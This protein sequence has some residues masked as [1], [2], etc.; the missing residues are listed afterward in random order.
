MNHLIELSNICKSF[1]D[2]EVLKNINLYI[3]KNEFVTLLGPSGCGKSTILRIIA[4]FET[5]DSGDVTFEG[6]SI[7]KLAPYERTVNTVFQKYALFPHLNVYDNIAFGLK[8]KKM[9]N[10]EIDLK[11]GKVLELVNLSGYGKRSVTSLSGGQQQ[12]IAIV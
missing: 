11:V 4:G 6:K 10:K 8:I 3:D 12:R 5:P 2:N 9:S 1:D 7:L